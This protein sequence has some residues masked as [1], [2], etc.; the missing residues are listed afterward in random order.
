M[1]KPDSEQDPHDERPMIDDLLEKHAQAIASVREQI[2]ADDE[3]KALYEKRDNIK[4]YDDIW[5][6]RY[7]L[8]HKGHTKSASKAAIKTIKFREESKLNEAGDLRHRIKQPGVPDSEKTANIDPLPGIKLYNKYC[9]ENAMCIALPD[10]NRGIVVFVDM[11]KL[12][13]HGLAQGVN[14]EEMKE[15]VLYSNEAMFQVVDEIT[16]RTRRLT[17]VTKIVDMVSYKKWVAFNFRYVT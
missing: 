11:G 5:I 4:R 15:M 2:L 6:L 16:R 17:K 7:V 12:D 13:Q 1:C 8:S 14:A 3:C 9:D 10:E